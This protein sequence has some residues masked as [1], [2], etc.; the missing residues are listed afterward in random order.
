MKKTHVFGIVI[1]GLAIFIIIS[2]AGDASTYV[3][4][5][6]A[7]EMAHEGDRSRIHVVGTLKKDDQGN[8][9]EV[10]A[11]SDK[12]SFSFTLLDENEREQIVLYNEPMPPDFLRSEQVVVV[13]SYHDDHFI[14]DK[15][16]MKCPSKYVEEEVK[17]GSN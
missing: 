2:T 9:V 11:S 14:A 3:T 7:N 15:I 13:G 16:L 6:Q 8:I 5:E 1:I 12:L 4:F 10:Q 17:I